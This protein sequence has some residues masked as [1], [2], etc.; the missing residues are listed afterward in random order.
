M[1]QSV[2]SFFKL[3]IC[4]HTI[5][6]HYLDFVLI[7]VFPLRISLLYCNPSIVFSPP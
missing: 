7:L 3:I 4:R 5:L 6:R 2:M 1:V